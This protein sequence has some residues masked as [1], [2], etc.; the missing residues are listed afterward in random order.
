MN[1]N[2]VLIVM[3]I[4]CV[5]ALVGH[6]NATVTISDTNGSYDVRTDAYEAVV[7][8]DGNLLTLRVG[9]ADFLKPRRDAIRGAYL[10]QGSIV[11]C[12]TITKPDDNTILATG[13]KGSITYLFS[14]KALVFRLSN[15]TEYRL[16]FLAIMDPSVKYVSVDS[17]KIQDSPVNTD[18]GASTWFVGK[19]RVDMVGT[20]KYWTD[21]PNDYQIC[22]ASLV[23]H[24]KRDLVFSFSPV[25]T[26]DEKMIADIGRDGPAV[27]DT[28]EV[29]SPVS[30]QVFQR[31]SRYQGLMLISGRAPSN[32][33]SIEYKLTGTPL[34]G[35]LP[36]SWTK[37]AVNSGTSGFSQKVVVPAGG[38]YILEIRAMV[39]GKPVATKSVLQV[40]VGE[41]FVAAGQSNSTN[42]GQFRS[43]QRS[44]MVSCFSGTDWQVRDDPFLGPHDSSVM[45]SAWPAF[46][47]AMYE[48]FK[49]PIAVAST[50]HGGTSVWHWSPGGEL[51]NYMMTR[52]NQLGPGGFRAVLWHQGESDDGQDPDWY[53]AGMSRLISSS[54]QSAK[55][56]FPWFTAQASYVPG[57]PL[58]PGVRSAQHKLWDNGI[59]HEGPDTDTLTGTNRDYNGKGVH[60]SLDGLKAHGEMWADKVGKY[61]D[62]VLDK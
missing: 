21:F 38:W 27:R 10:L 41:V 32:C 47:D 48:R 36:T 5:V 44:G 34:K 37:L 52:I 17:G 58:E 39:A 8:S 2:Y 55:W 40:G 53:Y 14:D 35:T 45:G 43:Q 11:D 20:T 57:K 13:S 28:I 9:G 19:T 1:R 4:A 56:V 16:P 62:T 51:F 3:I 61:L 31:Q 24:E 29:Y 22:E 50:G 6:A 26:S 59:S 42:Y 60:M 25:T 18:G 23:G 46:G 30:S 54:Y 49:V 12:S 33:D 15:D 7:C